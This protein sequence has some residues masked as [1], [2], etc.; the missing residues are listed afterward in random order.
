MSPASIQL[1]DKRAALRRNPFHIRNVAGGLTRAVRQSLM[2]DYQSQVEE[3]E[4]YI[5]ALLEPATGGADPRREYGIMKRWYWHT[6][7]RA[8][9]PY[10]TD[11]EKFSGDFQSLYQREEPHTPG[12][13]LA[14]HV[15]PDKV[16]DEIPS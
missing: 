3:T 15:D 7:A 9:N 2:A 12:L 13:P 8:P 16:N 5:G 6:S 10:R 4:T 14:T 1:I 11:M